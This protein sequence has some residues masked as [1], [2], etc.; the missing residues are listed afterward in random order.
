MTKPPS[1][2]KIQIFCSAQIIFQKRPFE[3]I[4]A[5]TPTETKRFQNYI[6][7]NSINNSDIMSRIFRF[8]NFVIFS[9]FIQTS[10]MAQGDNEIT[11][12]NETTLTSLTLSSH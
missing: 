5:K 7:I 6:S 9:I 8:I 2:A 10:Q 3:N 11:E 1:E 4:K 12:V